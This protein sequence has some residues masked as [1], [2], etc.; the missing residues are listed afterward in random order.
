M[1]TLANRVKVETSTTG[2]GS[3][4]TLGSAVDTFQT[5]A[6]GGVTDGQT[7][8]YTI[9]DDNG[10]WEIGSGVYSSTGPTLT[11]SPSESS[12]GDAAINLS[13]S[14][15]VFI[16]AAAQDILQPENNLSDVASASTAATNLGLGTGDDVTHNSL[17]TGSVQFT[18]GTGTQ[19]TVSW[20]ADEETLD[21]IQDGAT[22]QLGQEVQWHCRNNTASTIA[23]GTPVMATGTLG[24]SGRITIAPM[25]STTQSN[26]MY[27][28]GVATEDIAAGTDGKVT[29]FGKVRGVDTSGF[30]EGAVLYL[31]PTTDGAFTATEPTSGM[32]IAAAFVVNSHAVNGTLAVRVNVTD[33][34]EF[35]RVSDIGTTVQA[36]SSVLAGTT[37]S[38]TTADETKLDG[39][40][41]GATADQTASEILTAIKTVDGAS[42]G[43]DA[44]L[45]DGNHAT[46]FA[47]AAQ[48]SLADSALQAG[49]NISSLTN[50]AGYTTN[51]GD[52]T[53]V[54]AGSGLT[55]GGASG[56]VTVSHADTST[57]SSVDNSGGTVIQ[58]VTLDGFGHVTAL[59]SKTLTAAD[60]GAATAS[61]THSISQVTGLQTALDNKLD[62]SQ[63]GAANGLAE[64]DATGKVPSAQLPSY[65]DDVLEYAAAANFPATGETGKL[66]VALDTNDVYRW[67]GSAY[68]KVSDAVSSADQATKLATARTIS[69]SGD[70]SGST[71][72]DGSANV[73]ITATVADN[74]HNHTASNISDFTEAVQ[75][76][77][78]ADVVGSGA[79]SVSYNDTTGDTTITHV[80]TSSQASVNNSGATFIQ[81]VTLDTYGHVTGLGS[82]TVT[83]AL[84]GASDTSH[85]HTLDSLSNVTVTSNAAGEILKWNG[86][87]WIN[88]TLAEAGIQPAGSYLTGNQTITLSGDLTGSGT[89]SINAQIAANVVGAN[90]LNVTG[91]GTTAQFLRSDGDGSFTWA[92]PTDTDTTYSAGSGIGL[93]GTTFSVAAGG[94]LTQDASGLSHADTSAQ[95]S[96]NNSGATVIQDVTLDTYGHVTGL[97][98]KTLTAADVGAITGNQ[99]IT[100]SGDVS[101]SGTTSI[102]VTVADDSHN[103]VI[104][105][106]DGL[107]TALDGKLST[108]GIA[109]QSYGL[110]NR[111]YGSGELSWVQTSGNWQTWTG[112]WAS[113]LI[114]NHGDGSTYY[115]QTIIMPFWGAPYYMRKEG[116]VNTG[117]YKF[118][119]EE[120]DGSGSGLDADLLDGQHG[121]YYY[122]PSNPPAASAPSTAQVGSATAGLSAGAVGSYAFMYPTNLGT[123]NQYNWAP[124]TTYSGSSLAYM[125]AS[126]SNA[127]GGSSISYASGTWRLMSRMQYYYTSSIGWD[128]RLTLWLRIS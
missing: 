79:I 105:N 6:D 128:K 39:I 100:L 48:G 94:G 52:I 121:S 98:S 61:H 106:V 126:L 117:P 91:N 80:D 49:D 9:E 15:R 78:G 107:Q 13:G 65:V 43:L 19:G 85:N 66:Y 71:S 58:D 92:T 44:D 17:T 56:S 87:A 103:H 67:S 111:G 25:G 21:L 112:G 69:L 74:S 46:A 32:H 57:Q 51:V 11:R 127:G 122:S 26:A 114:S 120:N 123:Y 37:A 34:N 12:N 118:W 59:G 33:E 125:G 73:S 10:G 1:V 14:A 109:L 88:N 102:V 8:R 30:S 54:T 40:E 75:D 60:V 2:T 77:I 76:I 90:E 81:D 115:N 45:L 28:I 53:G 124:G 101:G 5:F 41:A 70:V 18:G 72:F 23:N 27:F 20:N 119:T 99:T 7:V 36:Y 113:H 38:F 116:G 108:S 55:G 16:T 62:D 68:V 24:A 35:V 50:D 42:S 83:P 84:I 95:A 47:T 97:A 31:D 110:N 4:I 22:L 89:T 63:K 82:V 96:V 3:T 29:H 86:T 64:L 93:S 104:S